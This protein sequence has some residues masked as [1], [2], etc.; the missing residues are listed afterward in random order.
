MPITYSVDRD[1]RLLQITCTGTVTKEEVLDHF[2]RLELDPRAV[3]GFDALVNLAGARP[4]LTSGE[5]REV[6]QFVRQR[7]WPPS[8]RALVAPEA[9]TFGDAR[10]F[11]ML[12]ESSPLT[13]S[14]F[15]SMSEAWAW[16]GSG[17]AAASES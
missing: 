12:A 2:L 1:Q 14:V 6:A 17:D 3:K 8:R 4:A 10:M 16:L 11:E 13:Y 15:R 5:I 9:R 7:T